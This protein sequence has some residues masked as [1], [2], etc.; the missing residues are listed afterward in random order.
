[1]LS[2]I[3]KFSF[4]S[5]PDDSL[6]CLIC[7]E[8]AEE[9]WEH[10]MCGRLFCKECLDRHGKDKPCPNCRAEQ[11]QYFEDK[12]GKGVLALRFLSPLPKERCTFLSI[13]KGL[14]MR[15]SMYDLTVFSVTAIL[16]GCH[17]DRLYSSARDRGQEF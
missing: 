16:K 6:K 14:G 9:P 15:V 13:C 7:L 2:R 5:E 3:R 17:S 8:V 12:R 1:M 11:P 10:D 4:V